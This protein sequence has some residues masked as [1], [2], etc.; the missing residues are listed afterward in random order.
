MVKKWFPRMITEVVQNKM[1]HFGAIIA[2]YH[3]PIGSTDI[4]SHPCDDS[5]MEVK[6]A[7]AE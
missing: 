2:H 5:V 7:C 4:P 1:A 3:V 6:T